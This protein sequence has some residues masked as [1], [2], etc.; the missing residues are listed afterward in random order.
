ML[1]YSSGY[2]RR[3]PAELPVLIRWLPREAGA[4]YLKPSVYLDVILYSA[5]QCQKEGEPV[6]PGFLASFLT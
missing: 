1:F 3:T 6:P 4:K 2:Q 5:E